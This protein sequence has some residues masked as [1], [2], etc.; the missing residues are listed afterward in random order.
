MVSAATNNDN[1][2]V[3]GLRGKM[4]EMERV[5]Q[6]KDKTIAMYEQQIKVMSKVTGN[7]GVGVRNN[8]TLNEIKK[9]ADADIHDALAMISFYVNSNVWG[10][11][12]FF[13]D[14][15]EEWNTN[16]KSACQCLM[17]RCKR[18]LPKH[19]LPMVFWHLYAVPLSN[20]CLISKRTNSVAGKKTIFGDEGGQV[21]IICFHVI[22]SH[23]TIF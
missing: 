13:P 2:T 7:I 3:E 10:R 9:S 21:L 12:K 23:V 14:R 20:S 18:A 4:L 11:A 16:P 22:L 8:A 1:D 15:W 17:E 6:S 5:I 19:W